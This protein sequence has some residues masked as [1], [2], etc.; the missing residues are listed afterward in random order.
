MTRLM[1]ANLDPL[2]AILGN[3]CSLTEKTN[4]ANLNDECGFSLLLNY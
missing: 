2:E 1:V 3:L 4:F